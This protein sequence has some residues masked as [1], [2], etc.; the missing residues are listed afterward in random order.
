MMLCTKVFIIT[1]FIKTKDQNQPKRPLIWFRLRN[2]WPMCY[3]VKQLAL[4]DIV[5]PGAVLLGFSSW[6]RHLL[7]CGQI[8]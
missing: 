2:H 1:L 5:R 3:N 7:L 4:V 6:V 8:I